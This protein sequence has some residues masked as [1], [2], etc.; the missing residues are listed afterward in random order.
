MF[1]KK[2][3]TTQQPFFKF[4]KLIDIYKKII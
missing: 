4:I 2:N 3:L 1:I